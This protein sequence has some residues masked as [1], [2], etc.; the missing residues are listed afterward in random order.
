MGS[1]KWVLIVAA[2]LILP[3]AVLALIGMFLPREHVATVR[4]RFKQPPEALFDAITQAEQF[5]AWRPELKAVERV[6]PIDGKPA[7]REQ[8][9]QDKVTY[10]VETAERPRQVVLRIADLHLPYGGTWTFDIEPDGAGAL[11]SITENGVVKPAIFRTL[12]RF[13]FGYHSNME[14]YLRNLAAKFG[15]QASLERVR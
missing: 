2:I 13:A 15:E 6:A 12:A 7:Y 1:M 3:V 11:V 14:S 5:T 10:V 8:T 9:G 4:A